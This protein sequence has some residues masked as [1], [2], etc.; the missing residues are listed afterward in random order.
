M[1]SW[2]VSELIYQPGNKQ[3]SVLKHFMVYSLETQSHIIQYFLMHQSTCYV[4]S[5][6]HSCKQRYH[7]WTTDPTLLCCPRKALLVF[8]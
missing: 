4:Q 5:I 6:H 3:H 7:T 8:I 2:T 1:I